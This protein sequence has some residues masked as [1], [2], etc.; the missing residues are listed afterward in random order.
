MYPYTQA[1]SVASDPVGGLLGVFATAG[2]VTMLFCFALIFI[3]Y[4]IL[5][6]IAR[7]AVRDGII[8]ADKKL[9]GLRGG[10]G[11]SAPINGWPPAQEV[12][13][14]PAPIYRGGYGGPNG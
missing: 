3:S 6:R 14:P 7:A 12:G 4:Y 11:G 9:G 10:G 13:P 1:P 8:D 5:Y 2:L